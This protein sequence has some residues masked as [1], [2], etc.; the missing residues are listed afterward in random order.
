MKPRGVAD[1]LKNLVAV[2][3]VSEQVK[4][5]TKE[6]EKSSFPRNRIWQIQLRF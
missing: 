4:V 5:M 2:E 3:N 1:E 6:T